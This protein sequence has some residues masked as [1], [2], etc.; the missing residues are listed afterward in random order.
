MSQERLLG[1]EYIKSEFRLHRDIEN[2]LHIVSTG[3]HYSDMLFNAFS[4]IS[5]PRSQA[6]LLLK[7]NEE[8]TEPCVL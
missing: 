6:K 3:F 4:Q 7:A 2:P 8:L 1:D 5:V